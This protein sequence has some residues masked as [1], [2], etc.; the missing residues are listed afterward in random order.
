MCDIDVSHSQ[1]GVT[2]RNA[3]DD[4]W[5]LEMDKRVHHPEHFSLECIVRDF[6]RT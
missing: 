4:C 3:K 5:K 2:T 6:M 1:H